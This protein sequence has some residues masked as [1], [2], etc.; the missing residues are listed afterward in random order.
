MFTRYGDTRLLLLLLVAGCGLG[1]FFQ[2]PLFMAK[3]RVFGEAEAG[4]QGFIGMAAGEQGPV[5]G[6]EFR[7]LA[8]F[9]KVHGTPPE[10]GTRG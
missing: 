7:V 8:G 1:H 10:S 4:G 2:E 3:E 9:A 6:G 5:D